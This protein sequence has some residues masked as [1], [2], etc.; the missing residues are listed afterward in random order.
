M[1]F[2]FSAEQDELRAAV[3]TLAGDRASSADVRRAND[4]PTGCDDRLW[5][6]FADEMGLTTLGVPESAGGAGGDFLDVAV[7]LEEGGRALLPVPL[8]STLVAA[9]VLGLPVSRG[10][11]AVVSDARL[12]DGALSGTASTVLDGQLATTFAVVTD[13]GVWA[14]GAAA[15]GVAVTPLAALDPTRR[16]AQVSFVDAPA[17]RVGDSAMAARALDVLRVALSVEAVGCARRCLEMT[18]E[19]LKTREQFGR[20]IGSFQALQHRVA[21]LAVALEAAA[22]TASYAAWTVAASP[23]ELPVVAPLAKA[24]CAD[25][26]WGVV[27]ETIQL[28]GGI[29]FTWEHDA[30]LYFKR[31]ATTKLLLGD[32]HVQRRLVAERAGLS[33]PR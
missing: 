5:A 29:G 6:V 9:N 28:H 18:V 1:D 4:S 17:E 25:A 24:V 27:A 2:T 15:P 3:R 7:L 12:A 26:A 33:R 31:V 22:S 11:V 10:A 19:H 32:S 23:E 16:Q 30:H 14:V 20:P 13:D 21:D 8:L